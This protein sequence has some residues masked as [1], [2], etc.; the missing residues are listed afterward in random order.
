MSGEKERTGD[1]VPPPGREDQRVVELSEVRGARARAL[2]TDLYDLRNTFVDRSVEL[3]EQVGDGLTANEMAAE[4]QRALIPWKELILRAAAID[5]RTF[6][7]FVRERQMDEA[8][9]RLVGDDQ[10][11]R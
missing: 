6:A 5:D 11:S 2:M 9:G 4:L 1:D 8:Y 3:A 10:E 7:K